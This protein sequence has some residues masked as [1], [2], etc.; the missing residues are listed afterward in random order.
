MEKKYLYILCYQFSFYIIFHSP[1]FWFS[2]WLWNCEYFRFS[3]IFV[4]IY[5]NHNHY[6]LPCRILFLKKNLVL[7]LP[8]AHQLY[9][10]KDWNDFQFAGFLFHQTDYIFWKS[11]TR[12]TKI[13]SLFHSISFFLSHSFYSVVTWLDKFATKIFWKIKISLLTPQYKAFCVQFLFWNKW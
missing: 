4:D 10:I 12:L 3:L 6:S 5:L 13:F 8:K 7:S 11:E 1:G 9:Y 2:I